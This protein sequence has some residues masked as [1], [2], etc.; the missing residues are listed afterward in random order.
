MSRYLEYSSVRLSLEP[1]PRSIQEPPAPLGPV[2]IFG[3]EEPFKDYINKRYKGKTTVCCGGR[4]SCCQFSN[5]ASTG[6]MLFLPGS[7]YMLRVFPMG[8]EPEYAS[9][10][11]TF[12]GCLQIALAWT[13]LFSFLAAAFTQPGIVPKNEKIP[14]EL[15]NKLDLRSRFPQH[16]FLRINGITIKQKFC[17]TC[18]VFRPPRSKHC[19]QCDTCVL[20]MDHHCTWLGNC[21][22]LNNYRYF[23]CLI[24]SGAIFLFMLLTTTVRVFVKT[25]YQQFGDHANLLDCLILVF[26]DWYLIVLLCYAFFIFL[27][28]LMLAVYHIV[29]SFQNLTTNEHVKNYYRDNPFDFGWLKNCRHIFCYPEKVLPVGPDILEADDVPFSSS[30]TDDAGSWDDHL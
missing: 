27:A 17:A 7:F 21:I 13:V 3:P 6:A 12:E 28:V 30:Y 25:R 16:R 15:E 24:C 11:D 1:E 2:C 19:Q 4:F 22:G 5:V 18:N 26:E 9:P 8:Y 14:K 20:R 23:V 29:I 10:T